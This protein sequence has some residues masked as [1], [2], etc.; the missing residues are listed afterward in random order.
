[1]PK[2]YALLSA[3]PQEIDRVHIDVCDLVKVKRDKW[4]AVFNHRLQL[5]EMLRTQTTTES[6]KDAFS[7]GPTFDF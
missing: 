2:F 6:Q 1:M 3:L 4:S 7:V 5:R